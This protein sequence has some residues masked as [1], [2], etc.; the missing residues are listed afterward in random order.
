MTPSVD[1][2]PAAL[3]QVDE[4]RRWLALD[5]AAEEI[6]ASRAEDVATALDRVEQRTRACGWHAA[7]FVAYEAGA[8]FGLAAC[9][10][11]AGLPLVWF[12]L[13]R[14]ARVLD[15][16]PV[17]AES[18]AAVGVPEPSLSRQ[19]FASAI[20]R[21]REHLRD[22]DTYQVNFTFAL[23]GAFAGDARALWTDLV[24]AQR[25]RYAAFMHC[26]SLAICSASPEL[27]FSR[28]GDELTARP[29]K[30]TA[31]RGRTVAEDEALAAELASSD[32]TRAENVMIVDMVR[33]DLGRVAEVGSVHVPELCVVERYPNVLQ[34]V[35][36]VAARSR[37]SLAR[38]F[39][40]VHPSA[41]ITGAPKVRTMEI[42][43]AIE[44]GPRGVY[45][46]AVGWVAPDG[47]AQFNV[48]IRTAVVD[49]RRG[50]IEYGVGAGIVWDSDAAGEYDESLLKARVLTDPPPAFDLLE[51]LRWSPERGFALLDRHLSRLAASA[52]HFGFPCDLADLRRVLD[53]A[54]AGQ[55]DRRRVRVLLQSDGTAR[56]ETTPL[57]AGPRRVPIRLAPQ[58]VDV[59]TPFVFHKTTYR[60]AYEAAQGG[61]PGEVV[62]WNA[63]GEITESTNA[64]VVVDRD[65]DLVTPPVACGLLAGTARAA[66]LDRGRIREAIVTVGEFQQARRVWV[67]NS[68]RGWRRACL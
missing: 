38:I 42:I 31:P 57:E 39:A 36:S 45:T 48:A 21:I 6:R 59:S 22:G 9:P 51:T 61:E 29:M 4:G 12:T 24:R 13:F 32:K 7:G 34:M 37:A 5:D 63:D 30:G 60:R 35:S 44:D 1:H 23:R 19:A 43:R 11:R 49:E 41:S 15:R 3:V 17:V 54:V 47:R 66:L 65:G 20:G 40:A 67:V 16:I 10:P 18:S 56:A 33:N 53:S 26:D 2:W 14:R 55:R 46:G 62:F 8:A 50:T 68:V 58:P 28:A 52:R 25:C 64:N 27:F